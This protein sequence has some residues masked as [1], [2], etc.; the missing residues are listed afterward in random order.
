MIV[1]RWTCVNDRCLDRFRDDLDALLAALAGPVAVEFAVIDRSS[2]S[3]T[4]SD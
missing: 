1:S 3:S 2:I 4:K